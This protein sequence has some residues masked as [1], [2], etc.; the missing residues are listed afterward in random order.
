MGGDDPTACS[1]GQW[2]AEY[3]TTNPDMARALTEI[4]VPHNEFHASVTC[5]RQAMQ[6]GNMQNAVAEYTR[7]MRPAAADVFAYFNPM[8]QEAD[9][10]VGL[11]DQASALVLGVLYDRQTAAVE[12][13]AQII[14]L[15]QTAADQA[16]ATAAAD[17][18][19]CREL[20]SSA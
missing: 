12:I 16:I 18:R 6:A 17:G 5:I 19:A 9:R 2:L 7:T 13:L 3:Q 8:Y 4:R 14:S 10:I 1:F 15:N 11:Y 20:R